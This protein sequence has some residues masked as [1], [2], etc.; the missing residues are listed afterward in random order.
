[1]ICKGS[2][3]F[4]AWTAVITHIEKYYLVSYFPLC[5]KHVIYVPKLMMFALKDNRRVFLAQISNDLLLYGLVY[6]LTSLGLIYYY[7]VNP[8][9]IEYIK[10]HRMNDCTL[11]LHPG[12]LCSPM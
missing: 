5:G 2:L 11:Q 4:D 1:M 8:L 12:A 3:D 7:C 10:G 6:M 9:L